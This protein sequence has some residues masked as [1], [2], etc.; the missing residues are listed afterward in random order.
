MNVVN[1]MIADFQRRRTLDSKHKNNKEPTAPVFKKIIPWNIAAVIVLVCGIFTMGMLGYLYQHEVKQVIRESY[2]AFQ[3]YSNKPEFLQLLST[4]Q[5]QSDVIV[6]Q[7]VP[8]E[9]ENISIENS[10]AHIPDSGASSLPIANKPA[11]IEMSEVHE[12]K[13][14]ESAAL[15]KNNESPLLSQSPVK[16][17]AKTTKSVDKP[18]KAKSPTPSDQLKTAKVVS[19]K[20][21]RAMAAVV[22]TADTTTVA[23]RKEEFK[24]QT[25][26]LSDEQ[27]AERDYQQAGFLVKR[28]ELQKAALMLEQA[29]E[30]F[31]Q[32]LAARKMLTGLLINERQWLTA[33]AQLKTAMKY[34]PSEIDFAQWLARIYLQNRQFKDAVNV[35]Q[36]REQFAKGNGVYFALLGIAQQNVKAYRKSAEAYKEALMTDT[37]NSKWWFGLGTSL[38]L[39][40]DWP[41]AHAAYT[42]AINTAQLS[43]KMDK[44]A[45]E[46]LSYVEAQ[47]E[48]SSRL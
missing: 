3:Q 7:H 34:H 13:I 26:P 20:M 14:I 8:T 36:S 46:R 35:L 4:E 41:S 23:N 17:T 12:P 11:Q 22:G 38:E 31:P 39:M 10:L 37:Y 28:G 29:L 18:G 1:Q 6:D 42:R 2:A 19:Q 5:K 16:K 27:L 44:Y 40:E 43:S 30:K 47:L 33:E 32:H 25:I 15:A 45:R 9:V 21:D 48:L 24:K